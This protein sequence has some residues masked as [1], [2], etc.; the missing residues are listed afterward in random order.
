[1]PD[2]NGD[3]KKVVNYKVVMIIHDDSTAE[4]GNQESNLQENNATETW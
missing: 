3:L 4:N 1:M 2:R